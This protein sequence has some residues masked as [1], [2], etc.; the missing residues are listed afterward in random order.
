MLGGSRRL[1]MKNQY[2]GDINDFRK[3]AILRSLAACGFRVTVCWMLTPD[4][5]GPDGR[6][7]AY[8]QQPKWAYLDPELFAS[9][10]EVTG[11]AGSTLAAIEGCEAL[12]GFRF[13]TDLVPATR[14][15]RTGYLSKLLE[16]SNGKSDLIFFDPDNGITDLRFKRSPSVKH[17]YWHEV[18]T[19]FA[20]G[21]SVLFYQHYPRRPRDEFIAQTAATAAWRVGV[22]EAF[23]FRTPNVAFFLLAQQRHSERLGRITHARSSWGDQ[24]QFGSHSLGCSP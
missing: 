4:D 1:N 15:E 7:V 23:A 16:E 10:R 22:A 17:L 12:R 3:Y 19:A 20:W 21:F 8:L 11:V 24:I 9:L 18:A 2:A 14:S 6:K 5:G 13:H